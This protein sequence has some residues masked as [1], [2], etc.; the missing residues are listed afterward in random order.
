MRT[1]LALIRRNPAQPSLVDQCRWR[2][3]NLRRP[4]LFAA[5]FPRVL[6]AQL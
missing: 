6:R 1:F 3:K 2:S 4:T 5:P